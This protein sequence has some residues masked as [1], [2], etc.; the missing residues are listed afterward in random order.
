MSTGQT[1][2]D[3]GS[4][5]RRLSCRNANLVEAAYDITSCP[6]IRFTGF[7]VLGNDKSSIR[8]EPTPELPAKAGTRTTARRRVNE[9]EAFAPKC[10]SHPEPA[11][12]GSFLNGD[13]SL[14]ELTLSLAA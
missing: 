6:Q 8:S 9:I 13:V 2:V 4:G 7:L 5:Y 10:W 12:E 11:R 14:L 1:V 3:G